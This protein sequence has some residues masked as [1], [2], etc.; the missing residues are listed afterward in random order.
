M[1]T[2]VED[3]TPLA[4]YLIGAR[5]SRGQ[6]DRHDVA[7]NLV[8]G[9]GEADQLGWA[10]AEQDVAS[11]S[12]S[13][14]GF[15]PRG[16]PTVPSR[17]R[18][19]TPDPLRL[20][21]PRPS[22]LSRIKSTY[23]VWSYGFPGV[24]ASL[25]TRPQ[26]AVAS[27]IDRAE[28]RQFLDQFR[29]TI[30]ASQLLDPNPGVGAHALPSN[31]GNATP[32]PSETDK[33]ALGPAVLESTIGVIAIAFLGV[34]LAAGGYKEL[35]RKRIVFLLVLTVAVVLVGPVHWKRKWLKFRR[36]QALAEVAAFVSSSL[37]FDSAASAAMSL[38]QEVELV[39]RGYR[40][41]V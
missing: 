2:V 1:E 20:A 21:I 16:R 7:N 36:D 24:L 22:P 35:T 31:A 3:Q 38:I 5:R 40:M 33:Q 11:S 30:V 14:P 8:I 37:Q 4:D 41:Y 17:F 27:R 39:S 34:W 13:S 26:A 32:P 29:Y 10:T 25:L 15:A 6:R 9:E 19:K 12:P 28:N 18:S 23:A